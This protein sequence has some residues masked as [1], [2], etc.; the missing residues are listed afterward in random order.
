MIEEV[1][2]D[3]QR[4]ISGATVNGESVIRTMIMSYLTRMRHLEGL[5]EALQAAALKIRPVATVRA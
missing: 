2:S 1:N 5:W 4:W 3:G